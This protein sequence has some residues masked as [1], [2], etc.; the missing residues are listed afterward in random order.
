VSDMMRSTTLAKPT[1][2]H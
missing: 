2:Q 1:I